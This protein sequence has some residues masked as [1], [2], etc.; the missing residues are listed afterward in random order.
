MNLPH[1]QPM[2][3]PAQQNQQRQA[4][5]NCPDISVYKGNVD[6]AVSSNMGAGLGVVFRNHQGQVMAS[7]TCSL[8]NIKDPMLAEAMETKL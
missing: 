3:F 8:S 7:A 2:P 1:K 5:W 4:Q 6:V